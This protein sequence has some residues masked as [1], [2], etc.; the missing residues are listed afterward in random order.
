MKAKRIIVW[1]F[2]LASAMILN[3]EAYAKN[4][5]KITSKKSSVHWVGKKVA[6]EHSGTIQLSSGELDFNGSNIKGGSFEVDMNTIVVTD[7]KD[8]GYAQKLEGHLKN[9]DFFGVD[10]FPKALFTI[11]KATKQGDGSFLVEGN[12]TIKGVTQAI[13]FKVDLHEHDSELH[14]SAKIVIDRTQFGVRYGSGSFFSNLGDKAIENEFEL[15][16][17]LYLKK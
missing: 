13:E 1:T 16:V 5:Y 12:A 2:V 9:G 3:V 8:P 10:K 7:I 11:E 14:A 4:I 6:G 17:N 15:N